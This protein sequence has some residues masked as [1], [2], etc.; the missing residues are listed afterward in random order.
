MPRRGTIKKR[1]PLP[2]A[3][4][5]E[6]EHLLIAPRGEGC[7]VAIAQGAKI[8]AKVRPIGVAGHLGP[9]RQRPAA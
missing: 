1:I 9:W 4:D 6:P 8:Q 2:D 7:W 5:L 3:R